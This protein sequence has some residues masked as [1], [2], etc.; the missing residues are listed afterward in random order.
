MEIQTFRKNIIFVL[1]LQNINKIT[2]EIEKYNVNEIEILNNILT[3]LNNNLRQHII[4]QKE[5]NINLIDDTK[6]LDGLIGIL[7]RLFKILISSLNQNEKQTIKQ[8]YKDLFKY[9]KI[10]RNDYN[11]IT[12][13]ELEK[14][15]NNPNLITIDQ[16]DITNLK[17]FRTFIKNNSNKVCYK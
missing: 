12:L 3:E 17:N 5:L 4:T 14:R 6:T 11:I 1:L 7:K 2:T 16:K 9:L 13:D 15:A 10:I 8:N